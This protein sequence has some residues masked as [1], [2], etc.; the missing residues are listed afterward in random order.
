MD[1]LKGYKTLLFNFV[2][3]LVALGKS[4]G[5]DFGLTDEQVSAGTDYILLAIGF[6]WM[7]GAFILRMITNSPIFKAK[8]GSAGNIESGR[9]TMAM[10]VIMLAGAMFGAA[11]IFVGLSGC[12]PN[13]SVTAQIS[14]QTSD[15]GTIALA[16]YAD[17]QDAYIEAAELYKP[18]QQALRQSNPDLDTEIISYFRKANQ[19]LDDWALFGDVPAGDKEAFRSYLREISI[20]CAQ[21]LEEKQK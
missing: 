20:R 2:M 14:E 4:Q 21:G 8:S 18:Y 1:F 3:F 19:V 9:I 16:T 17:A 10:M 12:A 7:I 11:F 13:Q 5:I 15:P 6:V